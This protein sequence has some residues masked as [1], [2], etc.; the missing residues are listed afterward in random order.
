MRASRRGLHHP[1]PLKITKLKVSLEVLVQNPSHCQS[2]N[3]RASIQCWPS[4]A[5][6]ETP[7][8]FAG[9]PMMFRLLL[10]DAFFMDTGCLSWA[11]RRSCLDPRMVASLVIFRTSL[12]QFLTCNKS[13]VDWLVSTTTVFTKAFSSFVVHAQ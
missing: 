7:W 4:S 3:Y 12:S 10:F 6:N 8:R 2:T 5:A 1:P 9:R 11:P 13:G